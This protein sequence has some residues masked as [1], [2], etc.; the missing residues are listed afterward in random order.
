MVEIPRPTSSRR[1]IMTALSELSQLSDHLYLTTLNSLS[2][3][4][5]P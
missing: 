1:A 2:E 3:F 5:T 4:P